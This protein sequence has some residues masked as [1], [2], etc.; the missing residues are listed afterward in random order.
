[1]FYYEELELPLADGRPIRE[2]SWLNAKQ[3]EKKRLFG[4][5][6]ISELVKDKN[7]WP[8]STS[9]RADEISKLEDSSLRYALCFQAAADAIGWMEDSE[10][11]RSRHVV[12]IEATDE[13]LNSRLIRAS[14]S[15]VVTKNRDTF[16][17]TLLSFEPIPGE[18]HE[19][20]AAG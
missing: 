14:Y 4:K 18:N 13:G 19:N 6:I 8:T 16:M 7:D 5:K 9:I 1:M 15:G 10:F 20:R 2:V 12:T 11:S 3:V 17:E